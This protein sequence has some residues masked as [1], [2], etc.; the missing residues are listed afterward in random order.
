MIVCI[1]TNVMVQARGAGHPFYPILDAC[2]W[3][4]LKWAVSTPILL[5]YEEIITRLSGRGAARFTALTR[6]FANDSARSR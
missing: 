1:D 6:R 5:E 3:G 2:V 4:R